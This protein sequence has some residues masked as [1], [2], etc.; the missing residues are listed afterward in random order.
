MGKLWAVIKREYLERVRN[1][2]FIIVTVFG[3]VFFAM[4]MVLPLE[5]GDYTLYL[6]DPTTGCAA[7]G[8]VE[9]G[10]GCAVTIPSAG[11]VVRDVLLD[12]L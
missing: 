1:K 7:C 11:L 3:P 2:W 8:R 5:A 6:V 12:R 4:I 9:E 10:T